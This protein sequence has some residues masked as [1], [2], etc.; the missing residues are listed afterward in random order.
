MSTSDFAPSHPSAVQNSNSCPFDPPLDSKYAMVSGGGGQLNQ[1][2]QEYAGL[3]KSP[4]NL[5][6]RSPPCVLHD[7]PVFASSGS[8]M[9]KNMFVDALGV[10]SFY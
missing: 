1:P 6:R 8:V 5:H 2:G 4:D 7:R 10:E 3:L 9:C